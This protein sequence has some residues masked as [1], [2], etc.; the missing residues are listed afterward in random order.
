MQDAAS[1]NRQGEL[2]LEL[3]LCQARV[4]ADSPES[5]MIKRMVQGEV[6]WSERLERV[7]E[8]VSVCQSSEASQLSGA[9]QSLPE[10]ELGAS[11]GRR[12]R[13]LPLSHCTERH[14]RERLR[15]ARSRLVEG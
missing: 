13:G 6:E 5:R 1:V 10:V 2:E 12:R 11:D 7:V 8:S 9:L 15:R 3:G 4:G 14:S